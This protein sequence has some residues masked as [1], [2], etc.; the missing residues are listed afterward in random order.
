MRSNDSLLFN[1][2]FNTA[3][4]SQF[5]DLLSDNFEMYHDEAGIIPSKRALIASIKNLGKMDYKPR[6]KLVEGS[7]EVF[8]LMKNG[9][10]YGAIQTGE[11]QFYGI[12][13]G[14]PE[15]L[16]SKARFT[17]VWLL[18]NGKWKLSKALSY[19]HEQA[20]K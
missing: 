18:E 16:T 1:V 7:L 19:D 10:L 14:K 2:G 3:D 15:Y 13:K 9:I 8:Q 4:T 20:K 6:R 12:E 5:E 11:H 17:H